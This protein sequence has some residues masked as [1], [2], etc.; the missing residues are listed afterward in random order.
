MLCL[1][2]TKIAYRV[3]LLPLCLADSLLAHTSC[4]VM[5]FD[6]RAFIHLCRF[7]DYHPSF[8]VNDKCII[9]ISKNYLAFPFKYRFL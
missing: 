6:E 5:Y 8:N 7:L 2:R 3:V 4:W 1:Q 9:N